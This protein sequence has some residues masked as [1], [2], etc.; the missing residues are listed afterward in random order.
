VGAGRGRPHHF[1]VAIVASSRELSTSILLYSPGN[2]VVSIRIWELYQQ[3]YLT[4]LAALGMMMIA[5][6]SLLLAVAY[7]VGGALRVRQL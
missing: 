5:A 4:E 3:G 7:R 2:E 6:L 1:N